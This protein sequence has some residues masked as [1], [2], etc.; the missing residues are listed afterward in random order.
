MMDRLPSHRALHRG[1]QL[2]PLRGR[3]QAERVPLDRVRVDRDRLG[4]LRPRA[5]V[6]HG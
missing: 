2:V 4:R 3:D 6:L 1:L 5:R